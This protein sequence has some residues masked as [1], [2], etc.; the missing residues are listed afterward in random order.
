MWQRRRLSALL[1]VVS[2]LA[3]EGCGTTAH[4]A[5]QSHTTTAASRTASENAHSVS[6]TR[7]TKPPTTKPAKPIA[8]KPTAR[9]AP[10]AA[11]PPHAT[12][13]CRVVEYPPIH[14]DA[15]TTTRP[16]NSENVFSAFARADPKGLLPRPDLGA[17]LSPATNRTYQV[18]CV[19]H[20][21]VTCKD[22]TGSFVQFALSDVSQWAASD[23]A[24]PVATPP[25]TT[26]TT[27]TTTVN[28]PDPALCQ[29]LYNQWYYGTDSAA[30]QAAIQQ[31]G[32]MNCDSS[33]G[34]NPGPSSSSP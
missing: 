29:S 5:T 1:V 18:A 32:D 8:T 28:A 26:T 14:V 21:T 34:S 30:G 19:A 31:Y 27:V 6:L 3:L 22:D 24:A 2:V 4:K 11:T 23:F 7:S 33:P 16:R 17:I 13:T 15:G 20:T 25:P 10:T 9:T 12:A